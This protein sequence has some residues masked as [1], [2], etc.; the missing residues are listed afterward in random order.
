MSSL[1]LPMYLNGDMNGFET[2]SIDLCNK[3]NITISKNNNIIK[4][5]TPI[6]YLFYYEIVQSILYIS[7]FMPHKKNKINI[8][9]NTEQLTTHINID[10]IKQY[11]I[12]VLPQGDF[13]I[14]KK[15]KKNNLFMSLIYKNSTGSLF[16]LKNGIFI[17]IDNNGVIQYYNDIIQLDDF[18]TLDTTLLTNI[19]D[20]IDNSKKMNYYNL[21]E[22]IT[23]VS[24]HNNTIYSK[25]TN[26]ISN[27]LSYINPLNYIISNTPNKNVF[28]EYYFNAEKCELYKRIDDKVKILKPNKINIPIYVDTIS[29]N[30][31]KDVIFTGSLQPK[32]NTAKITFNSFFIT[33]QLSLH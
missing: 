12:N 28:I 5:T 14:T 22:S 16:I 6:D 17:F 8:S 33:H 30:E 19:S 29:Y 10:D 11:N 3:L 24:I 26:V 2:G 18:N 25:I 27:G 4:I 9:T 23:P 20:Y 1:N 13:I 15:V 21:S 32:Y 31:N 7:L